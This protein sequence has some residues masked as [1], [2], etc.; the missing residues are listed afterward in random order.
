MGHDGGSSQG[1]YCQTLDATDVLTGW[2]EQAAVR[3]KAQCFVFEAMKGVR[4]RIPFEVLGLDSDNGGEFI[5][6]QIQRYCEEEKLTFTRSRPSRKQ[7]SL[8]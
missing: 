6:H 3:T 5:N 4:T 2:S 1:K 7:N 8:P